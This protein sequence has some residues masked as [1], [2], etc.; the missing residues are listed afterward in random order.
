MDMLSL[1]SKTPTVRLQWRFPM[2]E[3]SR[4]TM[5]LKPP[6]LSPDQRFQR[7]MKSA[8]QEIDTGARD[9]VFVMNQLTKLDDGNEKGI[10]S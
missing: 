6:N 8:G 3:L 9:I 7:M 1:P 5:S 2:D 10:C 4:R